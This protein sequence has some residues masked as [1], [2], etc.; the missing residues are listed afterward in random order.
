[1]AGFSIASPDK[2]KSVTLL[3]SK[4]DSS[5]LDADSISEI[6]QGLLQGGSERLSSRHFAVDGI[7]AYE[8][9]HRAG[10]P[11]FASSFVSHLIIAGDRLYTLQGMHIGGDVARASDLQ[12]ALASFHF[13]QPPS[14]LPRSSTRGSGF[15]WVVGI[16]L[17]AGL[18]FWVLR[19]RSA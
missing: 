10:K 18:L 4:V 9:V 14:S 12:Q 13:L 1:M 11:P 2:M 6:E 16:L 5:R 8:T 19:R 17:C 15:L 3:V 7:P